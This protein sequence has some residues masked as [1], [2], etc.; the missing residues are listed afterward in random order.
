MAGES[1]FAAIWNLIFTFP[2]CPVRACLL[3]FGAS[4]LHFRHARR[5]L[6]CCHLEPHLYG[7]ALPGEN[8]FAAIWSLIFTFP[9]CPARACLLPFEASSLHFRHARR[10]LVYCHL[11]PHLYISAMPGGSLF[12][13]I[14]SLF[15]TFPPRSAR[16]CL[17]PFGASSLR[18]R[19]ARRQLLCCHLEPHLYGSAMPDESLFAAI[20]SLIFT[21][22]PCPARACLLPF[23]ASSLPFRHARRELVYCHLEPHLY[24]SAMPGESLFTA[25][26]SLIFTFPLCPVRACLLLFGASSLHFRYAR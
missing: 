9:L 14:W 11:E 1:F 22:S 8:F 24:G 6:V 10:E 18:F 3:P 2:P 26:W 4:S 5:E 19:H 17:L 13:A 23:G 21:V 20:W 25:I 12:T 7:S 15:F 16:A